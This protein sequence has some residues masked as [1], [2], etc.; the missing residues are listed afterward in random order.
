MK[1]LT[2]IA[3]I[4]AAAVTSATGIAHVAYAQAPSART[5]AIHY[6]DLDLGS[7]N[8][9]A[10]LDHRIRHAVTQ[11]C[12]F[13]SPADLRG[14]NLVAECRSD[15]SASLTEQRD[16]VFAARRVSGPAT[17]LARR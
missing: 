9:R 3:T 17:L 14:Q 10:T 15:L 6:G 8:G 16:A 7:Q 12:G 5:I 11:A 4:A 1:I 13:A 2:T